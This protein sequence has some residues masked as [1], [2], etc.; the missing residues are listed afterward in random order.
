[1]NPMLT[2]GM[3]IHAMA[4]LDSFLDGMYTHAKHIKPTLS[5][6][7]QAV[8]T[9]LSCYCSEVIFTAPSRVG[10]SHFLVLFTAAKV[11]EGGN[12]MYVP[13]FCFSFKFGIWNIHGY[14]VEG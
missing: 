14:W 7:Y 10:Q 11:I 5:C 6:A 4:W 12:I 13:W 1:M 9:L 8:V 3:Y 2:V